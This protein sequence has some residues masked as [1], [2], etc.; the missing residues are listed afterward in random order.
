VQTLSALS[1]AFALLL[2]QLCLPAHHHR[3][4]NTIGC[5]VFRQGLTECKRTRTWRKVCLFRFETL[6]WEWNSPRRRSES[7]VRSVISAFVSSLI[8]LPA[9][10]FSSHLQLYYV[11]L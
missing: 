1:L 4:L 5:I 8:T 3:T 10:T 2:F 7:H 9:L 11:A 6:F